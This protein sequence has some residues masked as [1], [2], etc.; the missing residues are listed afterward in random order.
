MIRFNIRQERLEQNRCKCGKPK[1]QCEDT[2]E[3]TKGM[4]ARNF[5]MNMGSKHEEVERRLWVGQIGY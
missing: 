1:S 5:L 4:K 2:I 3:E